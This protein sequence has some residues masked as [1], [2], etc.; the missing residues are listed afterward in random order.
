MYA[1]MYTVFVHFWPCVHVQ[2][3]VCLHFWIFHAHGETPFAPPEAVYCSYPTAF[4]CQTVANCGEGA[5]ASCLDME[6][7][8]VEKAACG[9]GGMDGRGRAWSVDKEADSCY[10]AVGWREEKGLVRGLLEAVHI[11]PLFTLTPGLRE[12]QGGHMPNSPGGQSCPA[13]SLTSLPAPLSPVRY[14][15]VWSQGWYS[16]SLFLHIWFKTVGLSWNKV[17][18]WWFA[19][20]KHSSKWCFTL[21]YNL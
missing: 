1:C 6:L 12:A 5:L 2:R 11:A 17:W 15:S 9:S 10:W 3:A 19:L 14:M 7:E 16:S 20:E 8:N 21:Q 13:L 18:I 4:Q